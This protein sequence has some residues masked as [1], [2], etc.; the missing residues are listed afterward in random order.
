MDTNTNTD[1]TVQLPAAIRDF[2]DAQ[3]ARDETRALPLLTEDAVIVDVADGGE[4][5]SGADGLRRFVVEAGT[6]FTYTTEHTKV[7]RDGDVWVVG[8]HLEGDFPGGQVDLDYRF[9]LAGDRIARLDV[10]LG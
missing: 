10:V 5:F 8:H 2:L 9:T 4:S 1:I 3:A 6:E 7:V